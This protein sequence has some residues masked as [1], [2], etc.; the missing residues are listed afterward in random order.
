MAAL[1][2]ARLARRTS[3]LRLAGRRELVTVHGVKKR[4][5]IQSYFKYLRRT[6]IFRWDSVHIL[7]AVNGTGVS[8]TKMDLLNI[9]RRVDNSQIDARNST[10]DRLAALFRR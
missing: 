3:S 9:E 6:E 2:K 4:I 7:H 5:Y 10:L 8:A 1:A